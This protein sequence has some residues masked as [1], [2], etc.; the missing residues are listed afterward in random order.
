METSAVIESLHPI[1]QWQLVSNQRGK[2]Q[3]AYRVIVSSNL[4]LL[5]KEKGDYWD[6]GKVSSSESAISYQGKCYHL[7]CSCIGK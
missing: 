4:E 5:N 2:K 7:K 6:S 3:S 1:L